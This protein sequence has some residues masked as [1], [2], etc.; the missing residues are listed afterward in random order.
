MGMSVTY[1]NS[2]DVFNQTECEKIILNY[3]DNRTTRDKAAVN[4]YLITEVEETFDT[5][6]SCSCGALNRRIFEGYTCPSCHTVVES[7]IMGE[8][9]DML[10]VKC[11]KNVPALM[12]I[13]FFYQINSVLSFSNEKFSML[14][15][16]MDPN[17]RPTIKS[18]TNNIRSA[19][20]KLR[21]ADLHKRDYVNFYER[22]DEYIDFLFSLPEFNSSTKKWTEDLHY[23]IKKYRKDVWVQH[24]QIPNK[25]V[26]VIEHT[27]NRRWLTNATPMLLRAV[28]LVVGIENP[29]NKRN[30]ISPKTMQSTCVKFMN[31]MGQYYNKEM[32]PNY[33]GRKP[34]DIRK[35]QI[36]TRSHFTARNVVTAFSRIHEY[37][38][39]EMPWGSFMTLLA[40]HI[41][42]VLYNRYKFT[43]KEINKIMTKYQLRYNALLHDIMGKL[44]NEAISPVTGK[45]GIPVLLNRNP[46]LKNGSIVLLRVT[47]VKTDVRDNS[48]TTSGR[49]VACYN[50]DFDGDAE[51]FLL[52]LDWDT[53]RNALTYE[54]HNNVTNIT[55]PYGVDGVLN[56]P[57]QTTMSVGS[58][59]ISEE[60]SDVPVNQEA[61]MK[62]AS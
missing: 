61:M 26:T 4:D 54:V 28:R 43:A 21:E 46:T 6:P 52:L 13:K 24:I 57:K 30:R 38:E 59:L 58:M 11:P 15:Y 32:Y 20:E 2:D 17:Y 31:L 27:N 16:L 60:E 41:K 48:I 8:I 39:V 56:I 55:D 40:P 36:A 1:I 51:N 7:Q 23:L 42:S 34:G 12:N 29:D 62:W 19:L 5:V 44:I 25:A 37:D 10:W 45:R 49:I 33:F 9:K 18:P 22:F 35:Q 53:Y 3:L 47:G 50:G 14:Q